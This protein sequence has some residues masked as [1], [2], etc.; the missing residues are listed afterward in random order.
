MIIM[1]P[2]PSLSTFVISISFGTEKFLFFS[3]FLPR[4][5]NWTL[6]LFAI[7]YDKMIIVV[8]SIVENYRNFVGKMQC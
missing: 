5:P 8:W 6:N 3:V 1:F 7:F 4:N 2:L